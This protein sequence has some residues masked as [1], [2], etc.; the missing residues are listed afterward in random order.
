MQEPLN[1]QMWICM[2]V[3]ED[4]SY[5]EHCNDGDDDVCSGCGRVRPTPTRRWS[6][7]RLLRWFMAVMPWGRA[8][9]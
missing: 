7:G 6:I 5:C 2:A 3:M 1:N 9:H 8:S 4:G